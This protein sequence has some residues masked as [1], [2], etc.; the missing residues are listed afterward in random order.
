[1]LYGYLGKELL[2]GAGYTLDVVATD[3]STAAS[4]AEAR[5]GPDRIV[6]LCHRPSTFHQSH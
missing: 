3:G 6:T 4:S 1:L 2:A 5:V